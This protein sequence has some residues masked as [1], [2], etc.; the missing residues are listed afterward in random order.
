MDLRNTGYTLASTLEDGEHHSHISACPIKKAHTPAPAPAPSP[1]PFA[2][3]SSPFQYSQCPA[4]G[5][6]SAVVAVAK[7][8]KVRGLVYLLCKATILST[9]EHL[10][11]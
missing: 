8:S 1:L 11:L 2:P 7:F 4:I 9:F 5:A 10:G 3:P 6:P